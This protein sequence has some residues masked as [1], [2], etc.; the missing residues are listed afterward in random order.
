MS[1]SSFNN[2]LVTKE[3]KFT[4]S[5]NNIWN[6]LFK[7]Q[8]KLLKTHACKEITDGM[9]KLS[10]CKEEIPKFSELNNILTK[11]TGFSIVPV[12]GFIAE[13]LFFKLLSERKFPS[14]CFVRTFDKLDYLEEPDIFHDVF[15]HVPLLVNP[16]FA[17]FMEEFGKKGMQSI[18]F[19]MLKFA[20]TLYWFTVEFGLINSINGLKA[21]GAGIISSK[22]ELIYSIESN[23]PDRA[24]FDLIEVLNTSYRIDS[25]Q[26]KYFVIEDFQE[27]FD[28]LKNLDWNDYL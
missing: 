15:G 17:D 21:Y 13:D 27:L 4:D 1:N 7:R 19:N 9:E 22:D 10:I 8:S 25:L 26:T 2:T 11:E 5:D 24:K 12:N 16:I 6:T 20:A 23:I 14:T 3:P 28:A 18:E